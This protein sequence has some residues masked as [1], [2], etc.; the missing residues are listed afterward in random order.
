MTR[1]QAKEYTDQLVEA[2]DLIMKAM[3]DL[4]WVGAL[5]PSLEKAFN[6]IQNLPEYEA[7]EE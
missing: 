3:L 5:T 7:N 1:A 4:E 6:I 2:E